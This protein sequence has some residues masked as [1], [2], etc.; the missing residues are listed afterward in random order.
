MLKHPLYTSDT[1]V[2]RMFHVGGRDRFSAA[3]GVRDMKK[4]AR[5]E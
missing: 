4:E 5:R 1:I 2:H 3:F